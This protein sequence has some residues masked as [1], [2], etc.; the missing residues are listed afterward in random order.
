MLGIAAVPSV[1]LAVGILAMP[2]SPRWLVMQGRLRDAREVLLRVSNTKEEAELRLREIKA[3]A[4]VDESCT[5]DVGVWKELL[6]RPTPAVRRILIAS[7]G[8]HFFEHATGIEAVVLYTPR[9]FKKAGISSRSKLLFVTMGMGVTKTAFILVATLL[10][11]K[12]GRRPLLLTSVAGM[13]LSLSSLGFGLTMADH[14]QQKLPW[15]LGLCIVSLL[16]F[17]AFF[18]IGLAPVTWVYSSE[19]FP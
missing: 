9:I 16:L 5:D 10:L 8:I 6:L 4:G 19:I 7:L 14:S 12:V 18:S 2:E 3:A 17:V 13:I 11:D 15:A 1:M